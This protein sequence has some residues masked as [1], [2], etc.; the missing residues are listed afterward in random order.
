M[1]VTSLKT[2]SLDVYRS[3][4]FREKRDVLDAFWRRGGSFT[5]KIMVAALQYGPYAFWSLVVVALELALICYICAVHSS[6]ILWPAILFELLT[7]VSTWWA[8]RRA[9]S[10]RS[11]V[12]SGEDYRDFAS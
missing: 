2:V 4:S 1:G 8:V 3:C 11:V 9:G 5:P 6:F 7:L 10:L 12:R